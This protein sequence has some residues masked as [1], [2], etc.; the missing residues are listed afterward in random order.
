M[1]NLKSKEEILKLIE[2]LNQKEYTRDLN[3]EVED[4]KSEYYKIGKEEFDAAYNVHIEAGGSKEDFEAPKDKHVDAF[5]LLMDKHKQRRESFNI[6]LDKTCQDNKIKKLQLIDELKSLSQK[7]AINQEVFDEL[8][9]L[10]DKWNAINVLKPSDDK[11]LW[12]QY[13]YLRDVF[14][15]NVKINAELRELDFKKNLEAKEDLIEKVKMLINETE[16]KKMNDSLQFYHEQWRAIGPVKRELSEPLWQSFSEASKL[17]HKK[18]QDYYDELYA[19]E[20]QNVVLKSALIA[21][22]EAID[23][24]EIDSV[25][26]WNNAT[27]VLIGLQNEYKAIG[28]SGKKENQNLWQ[29]YRKVCDD[30][31]E[32]K[33]L[34]FTQLKSKED[35]Y[36]QKKQALIEKVEALKNSEE[37]SETS[38][39]IISIQKQWKAIGDA[40][41]TNEF[42]LWKKFRAACDYF[43]EAKSKHF[44]G[45]KSEQENNL[46]LKREIIEKL[47]AFNLTGEKDKDIE[48][49]K[50]L[51]TQ[52]NGIGHVPVKLKDTLYKSYKNLLNS[53]FDQLKLE[54]TERMLTEYRSNNSSASGSNEALIK[55]KKKLRKQINALSDEL[56]S[57]ESNMAFI[58]K[59]KGAELFRKE[60]EKNKSKIE[61]DLHQ[62]KS[63]LALFDKIEEESKLPSKEA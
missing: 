38:Q 29:Q 14:Y 11:E 61:K 37:W 51:S 55:E 10:Q 52:W 31:F 34:F 15:S 63:K 5:K 17:I 4:L 7:E 1:E 44:E 27:D 59:S 32:K 6:A 53:Y 21:K 24:N 50:E 36:K 57:I 30:F 42:K 49:L 35:F 16:I 8:K 9:V 48:G 46:K 40:G 45:K 12:G 60:V 3:H 23:I 62:L 41:K 43:F 33:S 25:K 26:E 54:E 39:K 18:R 56:K 13:N 2:T 20:E 58:S 22:I 19:Q 28:F 47:E